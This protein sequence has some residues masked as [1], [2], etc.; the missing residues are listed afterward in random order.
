VNKKKKYFFFFYK[1]QI[2]LTPHMES[3][4]KE[5]EYFL[6]PDKDLKSGIKY[7]GI[8]QESVNIIIKRKNKIQN[9]L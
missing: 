2:L 8:H 7:E 3:M 4:K 9:F 6:S 1:L 5:L